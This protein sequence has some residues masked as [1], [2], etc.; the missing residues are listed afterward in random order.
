[1]ALFELWI[2]NSDGRFTAG[3]FQIVDCGQLVGR[4]HVVDIGDV[5]AQR[6][7]FGR[8]LC[9]RNCLY[10]FGIEWRAIVEFDAAAAA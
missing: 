7:L 5:K 2:V 1:M 9:G 3:S 4:L 8:I 6:H 10:G